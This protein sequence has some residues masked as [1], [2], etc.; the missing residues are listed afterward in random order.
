[1]GGFVSA[2]SSKDATALLQ[3]FAPQVWLHPQEK[4][5]PCPVDWY[6]ERVTMGFAEEQTAST[7]DTTAVASNVTEANLNAQSYD[8]SSSGGA[9][10]GTKPI[11]EAFF[12]LPVTGG[13][14][15]GTY[16]G[17]APT[18]G[19]YP[20]NATP[21]VLG[22]VIDRKDSGGDV[23]GYD[24]VYGF[25]YGYNG[26]AMN[27]IGFGV[28]EGD[29]EHVVVRV[30]ADQK[31]LLAV[32]YRQHSSGDPYNGWYYPPGPDVPEAGGIFFEA[33]PNGRPVVYSALESHASYPRETDD[34]SYG[35]KGTDEV[36]QGSAWE[37][38][39]SIVLL[40]DPSQA[41]WLDYSGRMGG[42]PLSA[43]GVFSYPPPT[44]IVQGWQNA[45]TDGPFIEREIFCQHMSG[46]SSRISS[47][48]FYVAQVPLGWAFGDPEN[49][50]SQASLNRITLN[51]SHDTG[52]DE[53]AISNI[54]SGCTTSPPYKHT[55]SVYFSDMVYVDAA[56]KKHT[57]YTD[58]WNALCT[59]NGLA[60][61]TPVTFRVV[62]TWIQ[63]DVEAH[64]QTAPAMFDPTDPLVVAARAA[65]H[66]AAPAPA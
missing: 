53:R 12:S 17:W 27:D 30:D 65:S 38:W 2:L 58:A 48:N 29:L 36:G 6:L 11:D 37:T 26:V 64:P 4:Y 62:V 3:R 31:T 50:L 55:D 51:V 43:V 59:D 33:L 14:A 15:S 42:A 21:P 61:G 49:K 19:G 13:S 52:N 63:S 60:A 44:P 45:R 24:L 54:T 5:F 1:L 46:Q 18:N 35:W 40:N 25:F 39:N 41:A 22:G 7:Y 9:L 16:T 34:W 10:S 23:I 47:G 28:H 8:G 56:G 57:G 66:E 20:S 32:Y